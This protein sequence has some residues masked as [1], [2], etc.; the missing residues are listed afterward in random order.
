MENHEKTLTESISDAKMEFERLQ[1]LLSEKEAE[2]KREEIL[3]KHTTPITFLE[4][5]GRWTTRVNGKQKTLKSREALEDWIISQYQE[6]DTAKTLNDI[7]ESWFAIDAKRSTDRTL[8]KHKDWYNR[9]LK[10]SPLFAKDM[11]ELSIDDG[12]DW[13]SYCLS[14][15]PKMTRKYFTNV[16]CVLNGIIQYAIDKRLLTFNPIANMKLGKDVFCI[17]DKVCEEDTVFSTCERNAVCKLSA[18]EA[19]ST[20]EAKYYAIALLF[21]LP[22]RDGELCALT[23]GNIIKDTKGRTKLVIERQ[24]VT[25]CT[26]GK[27]KGYRIV[28]YGKTRAAYREITLSERAIQILNRVKALNNEKGY[29]T[30]PS[31]FIFMRRY[32]GEVCGCT[33]RCFDPFLRKYCKKAGMLVIKSP[34]DVRRTVCTNLYLNGMPPKR[35]QKVMGHETLE[36]TLEYIRSTNDDLEDILFFNKLNQSTPENVIPTRAKIG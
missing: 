13:V 21:E 5:R 25:D 1:A 18:D 11:Q 4:G 29:P 17:P 27:A 35:I 32:K 19:E 2:M 26:S 23:W 3:K 9:Y 24:L 15:H 6:T 34:H 12:Y 31:D 30:T 14:I 8:V 7:A 33:Q 28:N 10:D 16:R 20:G 36:Q 22:L